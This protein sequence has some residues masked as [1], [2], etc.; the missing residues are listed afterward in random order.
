MRGHSCS[1]L[2]RLPNFL[3]GA[4]QSLSDAT[5]TLTKTTSLIFFRFLAKTFDSILI[6]ANSSSPNL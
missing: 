2:H 6:V 1:A 4:A 3:S 5:V